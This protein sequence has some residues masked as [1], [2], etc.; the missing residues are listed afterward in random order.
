MDTIVFTRPTAEYEVVCP[1][2]EPI[3]IDVWFPGDIIINEGD[4]N[5]SRP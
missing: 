1:E 3:E 5:E 2:G 4:E